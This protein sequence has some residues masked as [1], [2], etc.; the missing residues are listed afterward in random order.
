MSPEVIFVG[1]TGTNINKKFD[2]K[3]VTTIVWTAPIKLTNF[4]AK[5]P[6]TPLTIFVTIKIVPRLAALNYHLFSNQKERK[7]CITNPPAKASMLN[8]IL[9]EIRVLRVFTLF[10]PKIN[11]F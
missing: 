9:K 7:L 4:D 5:I 6:L 11:V 10:I 2:G 3:W 1:I 8:K